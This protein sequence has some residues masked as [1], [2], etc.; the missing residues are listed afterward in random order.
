[1]PFI[2]LLSKPE[3]SLLCS[4]PPKETRLIGVTS[5][6]LKYNSTYSIKK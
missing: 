2:D 3:T 1:M 6:P 5:M 4:G